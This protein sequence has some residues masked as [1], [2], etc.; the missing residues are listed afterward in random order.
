MPLSSEKNTNAR[1]LVG[2][3]EWQPY[4]SSTLTKN[5]DGVRTIEIDIIRLER[6]IAMEN[7]S[8][9]DHGNQKTIYL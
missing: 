3:K 9:I 1:P 7:L 6:T 8:K 2:N 4:Q 5:F